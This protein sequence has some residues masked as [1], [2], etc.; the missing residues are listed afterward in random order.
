[1]FRAPCRSSSFAPSVSNPIAS[2][3]RPAF[4]RTLQILTV[5]TPHHLLRGR[6]E[7]HDCHVGLFAQRRSRPRPDPSA[8]SASPLPDVLPSRLSLTS[9]VRLPAPPVQRLSS[10]EPTVPTRGRIPTSR[11]VCHARRVEVDLLFDPFG[12]RVDEVLVG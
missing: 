3:K 2:S 8:R 12:V 7:H 10:E 5:V 4:G 6:R 9:S 1:M 11:A